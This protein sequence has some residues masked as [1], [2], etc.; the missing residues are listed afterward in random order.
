MTQT[1]NMKEL[2]RIAFTSYH[3]DGIINLVAGCPHPQCGHYCVDT[4][5][6]DISCRTNRNQ[7][8]IRNGKINK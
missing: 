2:E 5:H 8:A 3:E 1:I 4:V 6:P 7:E